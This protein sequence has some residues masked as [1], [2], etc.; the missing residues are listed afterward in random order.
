MARTGRIA[1][2]IGQCLGLCL[3]LWSGQV[4]AEWTDVGATEQPLRAVSVCGDVRDGATLCFGLSCAGGGALGFTLQSTGDADLLARPDLEAQVFVGARAL[5]PLAFRSVGLGAFE[6]DLTEA[7]LPGLERLKAGLGME[8]RY[9][10]S[11]EAPP[12]VRRMSLTG[13]RDAIEAAEAA[14]PLPDFAA[15]DRAARTLADPATR[16]RADMDE[17][18][19]ALGGDVTA[20]PGFVMPFDIDGAG[21]L[22]LRINHG[23]LR[24]SAAEN[25]VC[26]PA[27]CL[28]SLWQAQPDGTYL[29]VFLNAIQDA[30]PEAPGRVR[31]SLRG[32]LC[33]RIGAGPCT[34]VYTLQGDALSAE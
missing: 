1:W 18:C 24:C 12:V 7:H 13:S 22:D 15:Q 14:C 30:A 32:S 23:R 33:G 17:A 21:R 8:L 25:L 27:G 19:A 16:I 28:T 34:R 3:G 6:A 2:A 26:G 4:A 20:E 31:L 9:W 10:E 5:A 29:R 11:D